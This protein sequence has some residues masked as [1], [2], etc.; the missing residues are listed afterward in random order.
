MEWKVDPVADLVTTA[1]DTLYATAADTLARL[2]IGTAGQVL[3]VNSGAT[4]PEWGTAGGA[5]ALTKITSGS[6]SSASEVN[7]DSIFSAT[8]KRYMIVLAFTGS[9]AN[10]LRVRMRV[11]TTTQTGSDWYGGGSEIRRGND[12]TVNGQSASASRTL[13]PDI[14]G[15][16]N[17][18]YLYWTRVGNT[19]EK[20]NFFGNYLGG[21]SQ[22][23]GN[24]AGV[25]DVDD[26]YTGINL[27]TSAGTFTGDYQVYGLEN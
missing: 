9:G 3:K 12:T 16:A 21:S 6:Y 17:Q 24:V 23:S 8:Y 4:A 26:T 1:G 7:V 15:S 11:S 25:Y 27:T 18:I 14:N 13:M 10:A 2:A 19:S 22:G 5:S 20:P